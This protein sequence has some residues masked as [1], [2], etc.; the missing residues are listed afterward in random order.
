RDLLTSSMDVFLPTVSNRLNV[1]MKQLAVIATI[2][3]PLTF[4]TGF[5]GQNFA[6]LVQH[7]S[8]YTAFMIYGLGGLIIPLALLFWWLRARMPHADTSAAAG[9]PAGAGRR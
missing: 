5:F 8:S 7:I 9:E 6:W 4:I 2:F 1:V 3:L